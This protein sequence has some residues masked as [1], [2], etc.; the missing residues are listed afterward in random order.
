M[1]LGAL[2][3][4]GVIW[5]G[6]VIHFVEIDIDAHIRIIDDVDEQLGFHYGT[7]YENGVEVFVVTG[8][9]PGKPMA[10]AGLCVGDDLSFF[11]PQS[12]YEYIVFNQGKG[13]TI[14]IRR[15]GAKMEITLIVPELSLRDD[16]SKLHWW[17]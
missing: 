16:P 9:E 15:D 7:P 13:I 12:L 17:H 6:W 11:T 1:L 3:L 5:L 14:P 10:L 8:V 4:A 2:G